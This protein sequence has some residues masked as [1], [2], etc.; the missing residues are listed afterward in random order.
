MRA[1]TPTIKSTIVKTATL[2]ELSARL[3]AL[4]DIKT[5]RSSVRLQL[6]VVTEDRKEIKEF[7][8]A[9]GAIL[10]R[11]PGFIRVKAEFP[12][13]GSTV[14]D[15]TS[16]GTD[17]KV[18]LPTQ[19]RFLVGRNELTQPS[20]K[21][22]ENV[23]PQHI[24]DALLIDP[25]LEDEEIAFLRNVTYSGQAYHVVSIRKTD[26]PL[27]SR[28][29]W[30]DR[31]SLHIVRQAIYEADGEIATDAW[32]R[33]WLPTETIPFP[34][35]IQIDRPKDGYMLRVEVLKAGVNEQVSTKAFVLNPP[36]GVKVERIGA[37]SKEESQAGGQ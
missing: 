29:I 20:E 10:I 3:Q 31:E 22:S 35:V 13:V 8:E 26:R 2:E 7:T 32:Y 21:R 11:K 9:G 33:Q 37:S 14:F 12:V 23:R 6:S 25:P 19:E 5:T 17:Y 15:M 30:F 24:R 36:E 28:E 27:L 4:D 16:D 1:R 18:H 34:G